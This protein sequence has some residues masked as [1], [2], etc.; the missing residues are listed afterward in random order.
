[1]YP[2]VKKVKVEEKFKLKIT[3]DNGQVGIFNIQPYLDFGVFSELKNTKYFR[4][5]K[6][7]HGSIN[8][9]HGQDVCPDTLYEKSVLL[10]RTGKGK[11]QVRCSSRR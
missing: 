10:K 1:M 8:W 11:S 9:P 2:R 6:S 5:V 7:L 3:F 4:Q